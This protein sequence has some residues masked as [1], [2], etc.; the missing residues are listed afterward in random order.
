MRWTIVGVGG[1]GGFFGGMLARGGEDVWFLARGKHYDAMK[2]EGLRISSTAGAFTV[3][4]STIVQEVSA[5]GKTDVVLF[6]VKTYDTESAARLIAPALHADSLVISLQ[7]GVGSSEELSNLLARGTV[8][9]GAAYISSQITAPGEVTEV[10][11]F[12][13]IVF[14]PEGTIRSPL[15]PGVQEHLTKAGIK[16]TLVDD[17]RAELWRKLIFISAYGP[18]VAISRLTQG[19]ILSNLPTRAIMIDAMR[20]ARAV[21]VSLGVSVDPVDEAKVLEGLK[22][23]S[24]D[25]RSSMYFD[26]I[27]QKPLEVEALNGTIVRLGL[28]QG[29][30]TPIHKFF[31]SL[32]LPH[33][34]KHTA[35]R[36]GILSGET[37][38]S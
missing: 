28:Q 32:L 24:D 6:C 2:R 33:H 7:N 4:P 9:A 29:I 21:A 35:I 25:S 3:P 17:V 34:L 11:G 15:G 12:Q 1:V 16:C 27:S 5:I 30:E 23:F 20:E 26:L 10:G 37:R 36:A 18:L 8:Y 19:E 22:R 31:Y 14:G 38:A 13:R